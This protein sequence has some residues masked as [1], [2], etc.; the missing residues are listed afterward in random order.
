MTGGGNEPTTTGQMVT[1]NGGTQRGVTQGLLLHCNAASQ[2]NNLQVNWA[3]NSF[4]L[5]QLVS[6][7]CSNDGMSPQPPPAGFDVIQ[8]S[9]TG[10]CNK[11]AATVTFK[12]ADHGEPGTNDTVEIHITG[13]CTLDVSGNLKGG[14]IQAHNGQ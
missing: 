2:S 14:D 1:F 7:T 6:A 12:F 8:G 9:G 11:L 13:G 10:K 4:H 5:Q 3:N